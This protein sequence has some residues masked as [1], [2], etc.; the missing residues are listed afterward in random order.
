[1]VSKM[2]AKTIK[3]DFC[4]YFTFSDTV[5]TFMS[6]KMLSMYQMEINLDSHGS[7]SVLN[8]KI[9]MVSKMAAKTIN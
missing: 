7:N 3:M 8:S 5:T 4:P 6:P 2:A 9:N 1:M